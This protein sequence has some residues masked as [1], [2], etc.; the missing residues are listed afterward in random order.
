MY[1]MNQLTYGPVMYG[2]AANK[3]MPFPGL[4]LPTSDVF[5]TPVSVKEVVFDSA[6]S[7]IQ[8]ECFTKTPE[9]KIRARKSIY[10][11]LFKVIC[12]FSYYINH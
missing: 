8:V 4:T 6:V 9:M 3:N 7:D 10:L 12:Y 1:M 11:G 2:L 5:P